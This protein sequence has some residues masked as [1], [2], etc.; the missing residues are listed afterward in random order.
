MSGKTRATLRY[1]PCHVP[2]TCQ[3]T[4]EP[5]RWRPPT[6]PHC[7][8]CR[9]LPAGLLAKWCWMSS[10][11]SPWRPSSSSSTNTAPMH[12]PSMEHTPEISPLLGLTQSNHDVLHFLEA[13]RCPQ[14]VVVGEAVVPAPVDDLCCQVKL[15]S[16]TAEG[17]KVLLDVCIELIDTRGS[18][19]PGVGDAAQ[20]ARA[21]RCRCASG[22][23]MRN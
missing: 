22:G 15:H 14:G 13:V 8:Y 1:P 17:P 9:R 20:G 21:V 23:G 4:H 19:E 5:P 3:R 18:Q 7:R 2:H 12:G 11:Q 6:G 16:S 10:W